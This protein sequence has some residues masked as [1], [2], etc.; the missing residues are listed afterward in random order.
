MYILDGLWDGTD[1]GTEDG[2][3]DEPLGLDVDG[4]SEETTDGEMDDFTM[5][6]RV[7]ETLGCWDGIKTGVA[8]GFDEGTTVVASCG[9]EVD[10]GAVEGAS[11]GGGA[12]TLKMFCNFLSEGESGIIHGAIPRFRPR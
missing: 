3:E 4:D 7:G 9:A 5:E 1:D 2:T 12:M 6:T 8:V 10:D 11:L